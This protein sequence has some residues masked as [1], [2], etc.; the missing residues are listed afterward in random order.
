MEEIK[1]KLYEQENE[2]RSLKE[3]VM[4][5]F[6]GIENVS[7]QSQKNFSDNSTTCTAADDYET[8]KDEMASDDVNIVTEYQIRPALPLPV[9]NL[10]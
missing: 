5:T 2:M 9:P 3:F 8:N 4:K 6:K 1:E 7:F 10:F